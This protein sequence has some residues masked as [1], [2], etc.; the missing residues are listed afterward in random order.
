VA[1][2]NS[3]REPTLSS[4]LSATQFEDVLSVLL[5]CSSLEVLDLS[6]NRVSGLA[7]EGIDVDALAN[8]V[9]TTSS[10]Q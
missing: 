1:I 5:R 8:D 6:D 2:G 3:L 10:L 9:Q 4:D 7:F